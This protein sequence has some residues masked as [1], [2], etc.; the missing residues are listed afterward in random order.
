ML[1][2]WLKVMS[3]GSFLRMVANFTSLLVREGPSRVSVVQQPSGQQRY[4]RSGTEEGELSSSGD[5]VPQ[6]SDEGV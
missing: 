6:L 5:V 3:K 1:T 2:L 4:E